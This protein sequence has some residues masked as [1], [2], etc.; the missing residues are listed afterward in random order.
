MALVHSKPLSLGWEAGEFNLEGTDGREYASDDF[1][2]KKGLLVFF[3]C[4]HCPYAKAAW[5]LIL[6]LHEEFGDEINFVAINPN[7][8]E[9]YPE[10]SLEGMKAKVD[11]LQVELP[12]L[13]D[14][15]QEVAQVY[16]AQCTPDLYLFKNNQGE[17]NLYYH[18]RINDNWQQADQAKEH[19]L[20]EAIL[21]L[22]ADREPPEDQP[23]SMGCSIK[24]KNQ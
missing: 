16:Q 19:N 1:K 9:Q 13:W 21:N 11:E 12:Y 6:D 20:E 23:A 24:W 15:T 22:L 18:G 5:P 7:D 14:E 2:N 3:T 4:N 17:L 10:D 8:P